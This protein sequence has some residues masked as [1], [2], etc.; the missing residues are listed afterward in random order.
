MDLGAPNFHQTMSKRI[1]YLLI[2]LF[3]YQ[4]ASPP[5][6]N[7]E[8]K[9]NTHKTDKTEYIED[10]INNDVYM[11]DNLDMSLN[12]DKMFITEVQSELHT[13]KA[14]IQNL[15][16]LIKSLSQ[17]VETKKTEANAQL[18][19]AALMNYNQE[20]VMQSG[21]VYYGNII[22]QDQEIVTLETLIG[23][24]NIDRS[25]II[26]VVSYQIPEKENAVDFPEMQLEQ[27]LTNIDD[28]NLLY[29]KPAEIVLLGNITSAS[30]AN[31]STKLS[32]AVKN[33]GGKRA[34]FVKLNITL[35]RD[36]SKQ[37]E[38]KTFSV[39]VSGEK[40]YLNPEDSSMVSLNSLN[41]KSEGTFELYIPQTFGTVMSWT[42][43]I[44]YEEYE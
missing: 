18:W 28:G 21:T 24:L 36:W 35:F 38:P 12:E 11:M 9:T 31:G 14:E 43:N 34:D 39:F 29:K 23:K 20:V 1:L 32:G 26:R 42:Y 15:R 27:N 22:Y 7:E 5:A 16:S 3:A 10:L 2:L 17:Q 13:N 6:S 8:L 4:C 19:D 37:L 40:K 33:I 41:P 44:D 30:D 25:Q